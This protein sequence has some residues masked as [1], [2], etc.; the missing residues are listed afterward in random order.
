MAKFRRVNKQTGK[1]DGSFYGDGTVKVGAKSVKIR[2]LK[3]YSI[4][5][6]V[7]PEYDLEK[8]VV[9]ELYFNHESS[10][11]T[12][13]VHEFEA[14]IVNNWKVSEFVDNTLYRDIRVRIRRVDTFQGG[15]LESMADKLL[16]SS[17][18]TFSVNE[19]G[20]IDG[21]GDF[22]EAYLV[23]IANEDE[24]PLQAYCDATEGCLLQHYTDL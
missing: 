12:R 23:E 9:S 13:D 19:N 8:E 1:L 3:N 11:I 2:D 15:V 14:G 6:Q 10:I 7:E 20:E 16:K 21:S 17:A 4:F 24:L 22:I 18:P 5:P